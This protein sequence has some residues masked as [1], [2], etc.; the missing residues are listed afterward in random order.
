MV[1]TDVS[2][3]NSSTPTLRKSL[4]FGVKRS[5]RPSGN[6][7]CM[8]TSAGLE[9]LCSTACTGMASARL[10]TNLEGKE[11]GRE[12]GREGEKTGKK[13]QSTKRIKI[14]MHN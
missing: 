5:L 4:A 13:V 8:A 3:R 1:T 11:G 14:H 7:S 12:G 10:Y 6:F 2:S 9:M